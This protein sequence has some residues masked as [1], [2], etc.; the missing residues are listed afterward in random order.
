MFHRAW[1]ETGEG[2]GRLGKALIDLPFIGFLGIAYGSICTAICSALLFVP[3]MIIRAGCYLY[4]A[5]WYRTICE[6]NS[7]SVR[8]FKATF[9]CEIDTQLSGLN[10]IV[11]YTMNEVDLSVL[12]LGIVITGA[13]TGAAFGWL[14]SFREL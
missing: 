8:L 3:V 10:V 1:K 2:F 14:S 11:R 9:P 7:V 12:M 5:V 6:L 13:L 4:S